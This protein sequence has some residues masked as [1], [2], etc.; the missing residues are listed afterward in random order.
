MERSNIN[1]SFG[2]PKENQTLKKRKIDEITEADPSLSLSQRRSKNKVKLGENIKRRI[3]AED[4][5]KEKNSFKH[6]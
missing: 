1:Q 5:T 3:R 2:K 6:G 4:L